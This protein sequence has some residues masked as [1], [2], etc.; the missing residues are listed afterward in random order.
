MT[1][2]SIKKYGNLVPVFSRQSMRSYTAR[3]LI[4]AMTAVGYGCGGQETTRVELVRVGGTVRLDGT[5]LVKAVVVFEAP[6]ASFSYSE[7]DSRGRYSLRF[8]SRN[9]GIKAGAKTVRIS[10]NRR[11]K[12]LNSTDEGGPEDKAG[13]WFGKQPPESIP[14]RYNKQ[15][16]LTADVSTTSRKF[17]YDLTTKAE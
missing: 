14:E 12:G 9:Y 13:G 2:K 17:N 4:L 15:S 16:T 8:D 5:P 1:T 6:D 11:I 10:M 7:T 3:M